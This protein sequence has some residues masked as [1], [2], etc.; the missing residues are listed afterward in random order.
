MP[1]K[2]SKVPDMMAVELKGNK[3][4]AGAAASERVKLN[5]RL[6][7]GNVYS[8]YYTENVSVNFAEQYVPL[9][10]KT[11]DM[12]KKLKIK[13]PYGI[14]MLKKLK[15]KDFDKVFD[16][17]ASLVGGIKW[18][19]ATR[20]DLFTKSDSTRL[21]LLNTFR[22]TELDMVECYKEFY[23][24]KYS[25]VM[26]GFASEL[27]SIG[28]KN[29][30]NTK[31]AQLESGSNINR[32]N[33]AMYEVSK[34]LGHEK[35]ICQS[36]RMTTIEGDVQK[37]GT[38]MVNAEGVDYESIKPI[39]DEL[40]RKIPLVYTPEAIKD[41]S[42][43]QVLDY[44]CGNED[45][46]GGNIFYKMELRNKKDGP[47]REYVVTGYQGIDNDSS[48]GQIKGDG[49]GITY[50]M[51]NIDDIKIIDKEQRDH[52]VALQPEAFEVEM[53]KIGLGPKEIDAGMHRL[54]QLKDRLNNNQIEIVETDEG[55]ASKKREDYISFSDKSAHRNIWG[56]SMSL[57]KKIIG[58][59]HTPITIE[60]YE[61][62]LKNKKEPTQIAKSKNLEM[63]ILF[64]SQIATLK[65]TKAAFDKTNPKNGTK[66]FKK[67]YDGMN[68]LIEKME[69][70]AQKGNLTDKEY[71]QLNEEYGKEQK[72]VADYVSKK[73]K[74]PTTQRGKDRLHAAKN[75]A[76]LLFDGKNRVY[77]ESIAAFNRSMRVMAENALKEKDNIINERQM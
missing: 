74:N 36:V 33:N 5:V 27:L 25:A 2:A 17:T 62:K 60:Q 48:F 45:R 50:Y 6:E 72:N 53:R 42:R 21:F 12:I 28:V 56:I 20:K 61:E 38:F 55:W 35:L 1:P 32:R 29:R 67:M 70:A 3:E 43:L 40:G 30:I 49:K 47:G 34:L 7:D 73:P 19:E 63:G 64:K 59:K 8:G 66:E 13:A 41:L 69:E 10:D 24:P 26:Q 77:E 65:E 68:A 39:V 52:I 15:R 54:M 57:D 22:T 44:L 18:Q 16:V 58:K 37:E 31:Q 75:F 11:I 76:V 23:N 9:I 4:I 51:S 14:D 71:N 46:H